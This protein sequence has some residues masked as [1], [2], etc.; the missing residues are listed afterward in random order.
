MKHVVVRQ[1]DL[2]FEYRHCGTELVLQTP[3]KVS[4]YVAAAR[5]FERRHKRCPA[6]APAAEASEEG[7][8]V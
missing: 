6:P 5:D 2:G 4:E 1:R 8:H 3:V 7:S